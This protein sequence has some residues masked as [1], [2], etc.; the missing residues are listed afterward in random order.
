MSATDREAQATACLKAADTNRVMLLRVAT[1]YAG[2]KDGGM[3]LYQQTLLNCHDAIQRNGF[4]GGEPDLKFYLLRALRTLHFAEVKRNL[5]TVRVPVACD[6]APHE[7]DAWPPPAPHPLAGTVLLPAATDGLAHL[8]AQ[9]S[10]AVREQFPEERVVVRLHVEGHSYKAIGEMTGR[11][12]S[13][14]QRAVRRIFTALAAQFRS[15]YDN[16]SD[17]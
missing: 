5:K 3:D 4:P 1:K 2:S 17:A 16:L 11:D 14:L 6:P 8:A 15:A 12:D 13:T 7:A 10:D 9:L